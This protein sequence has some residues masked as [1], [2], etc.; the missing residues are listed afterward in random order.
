MGKL[1]QHNSIITIQEELSINSIN[2]LDNRIDKKSE[3]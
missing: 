1:T 2:K 3:V